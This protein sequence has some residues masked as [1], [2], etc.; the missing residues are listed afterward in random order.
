MT[1]TT[2]PNWWMYHGDPAHTGYVTGSNI[3]SSTLPSLKALH[4]LQV[5]G[6]ILG[7][8]A[9]VDGFAYVGTANFHGA[10]S[11]NGGSLIKVNIVTGAIE[12][13]YTWDIEADERDSHG[14]TGMGCTPAVTD[15][16]VYF[17]AFNG[18]FYCL[19]ADTLALL[20][21]TDLRMADLAHNQPVTNNEG[22]ADGNPVAA[23]WSSPV[24]VNGRLYVGMGEGENPYLYGFVYCLD[25]NSGDIIWIYCTCQFEA[26]QNNQPNVLPASVVQNGLP[27]GFSIHS[28]PVV[29]RGCSI[30]SSIAYDETLNRLYCATGNPADPAN[31]NFDHGLPAAGYAYGILALDADSGAFMGFQ[32]LPQN[33]SYRP[34]DLDIDFGGSPTVFTLNGRRVVAAGC[35]NGALFIVDAN[36]LELVNWR[37]MLPFFNN[38]DKIPTVDPHSSASGPNPH[39]S[40]D[41]SDAT[42]AENFSGTYSTPAV[43]PD[44]GLLFIGMGGS[45]DNLVSSGIDSTTTPFMR[46]M[47]TDTLADAW[48]MD[49]NDPRRYSLARPPMYSHPAECGLSMPAIVNDVV[50]CATTHV[51]LYAFRAQ[52][53]QPLWQD[54]L[55]MQ[56]LGYNGGYGFCFGPAIWGDYVVAGAL[57]N[58]RD[59]GTLKI[60]KL[61]P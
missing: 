38:G 15:G 36:T 4:Q 46:A 35:K 14:F 30:W 10:T 13:T 48:P 29:S 2:P 23:G 20:W 56:T 8:P 16:K 32:Q 21:V 9:V 7:V 47:H 51:S 34:S 27:A 59:G 53:G 52:D 43:H 54:D 57:I 37:Q 11:G 5:N 41:E 26:G 61:Q 1:T 58:G 42:P 31:P 24:A 49:D 17:S 3:S 6:S 45:N 39:P 50:F 12:Q 40:N 60:Y 19:S 25:G 22:V 55:G 44:L 33:S 28:G 18:K